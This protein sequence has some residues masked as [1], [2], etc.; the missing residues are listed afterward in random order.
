MDLSGLGA[1]THT[2]TIQAYQIFDNTFGILY[3]G[4]VVT[5]DLPEP[6]TFTLLPFGATIVARLRRR[7]RSQTIRKNLLPAHP[8]T[9]SQNS[10]PRNPKMTTSRVF[11][12]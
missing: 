3:E 7:S 11:S 1:G 2:L 6:A 12:K 10:R 4:N 5:A 9:Y 8:T